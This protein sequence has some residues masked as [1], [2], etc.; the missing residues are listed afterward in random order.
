MFIFTFV[1]VVATPV[2]TNVKFAVLSTA[3]QEGG[4]L[5]MVENARLV[6][7]SATVVVKVAMAPGTATPLFYRTT[8]ISPTA[9]V[10]APSALKVT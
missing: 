9:V 3:Q 2:F 5:I 8:T 6:A 10:A 1:K 7:S 4:T